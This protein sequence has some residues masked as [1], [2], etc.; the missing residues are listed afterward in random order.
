[1]DSGNPFNSHGLTSEA[2]PLNGAKGEALRQK[3]PFPEIR[4]AVR[5]IC[6]EI[7]NL[8][9][10]EDD[11]TTS[12]MVQ[13]VIDRSYKEFEGEIAEYGPHTVYFPWRSWNEGFGPLDPDQGKNYLYV[14]GGYA[15]EGK[16]SIVRQIVL[17][18]LKR[19]KPRGISRSFRP[20]LRAG[21]HND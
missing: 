21:S 4:E 3:E 17:H 6:T 10:V 7:N 1:M 5:S 20:T 2:W 9:V 18:N 14:I 15:S 8:T 12:Q 13:S 16:S 11:V 19:G